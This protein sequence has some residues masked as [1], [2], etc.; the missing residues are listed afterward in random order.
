MYGKVYL[1]NVSL[2][3]T[4]DSILVVRN[5]RIFKVLK[6]NGTVTSVSGTSPISVANG[7]TTP[8]I[9]L[10]DLAISKT[11]G[12]SDSLSRG[13]IQ[14]NQKTTGKINY[15]VPTANTD[16]ARGVA[17]QNA[18]LAHGKSDKITI[19]AGRYLVT[20][21]LEIKDS[22]YVELNA[23]SIYHTNNAIDIFVLDSVKNVTISGSGMLT[24]A[25]HTSGGTYLSESGIRLTG[26]TT[27]AIIKDISVRNFRGSG[28][29]LEAEIQGA[30]GDTLR[31]QNSMVS[32]ITAINNKYGVYVSAGYYLIDQSNFTGNDWGVYMTGANTNLIN[33]NINYNRTGIYVNAAGD[34]S[35]ITSNSINHNVTHA[36]Y[37]DAI[38]FGMTLTGNNIF[39]S[40]PVGADTTIVINNSKGIN[41]TGG[42]WGQGGVG[43]PIIIKLMGA[44]PGYNHISNVSFVGT[45]P[46][47]IG[48]PTQKSYLDIKGTW[49]T[50]SIG[51]YINTPFTV[52]EGGTGVKTITGIV[53]GNGTSAFTA[54]TAGTDYQLPYLQR[55]SGAL[56]PVTITDNFGIGTTAP[57]QIGYGAGAILGV[58]SPSDDAPSLQVGKLGSSGATTGTLG[59][60][61]FF[62][63]NATGAVVNRAL[64]RVGLDG[65]TNSN[66]Y[67]FWTMNAGTLSEKVRISKDGALTGTSATFT[68]T[69]GALTI[70]RLTTAQRDA[71]TPVNG[72]LIYNSTTAKFQ[73]YEAG[74]WVNLI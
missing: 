53:K 7:T 22:V 68:T 60:L 6:T 19:G 9:S 30:T 61:N 21:A 42:V 46:S 8:V 11:T 70:P 43:V 38:Q 55:N 58:Y 74:A 49:R 3:L 10:N 16:A 39:A 20:T 59:D 48:T 17:L 36:I 27:G 72:M 29:S 32:N 73:G 5:G 23:A 65:D 37:F 54:A 12:L 34:H 69:T 33:S 14:V 45:T 51:A 15:Y 2:G 62:G 57:D 66:F 41:I 50:D 64:M 28:I 1:K 25:G 71:L 47:V 35:L 31:F 24:G 56:A 67:S 52:M 40:Y 13:Y 26:N 18:V 4:S 44:T 63:K